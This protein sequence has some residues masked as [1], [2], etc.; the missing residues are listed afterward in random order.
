[1]SAPALEL[2][3][4]QVIVLEECLHR[5]NDRSM[6]TRVGGLAGT[7]KTSIAVR[8]PEWLG[9]PA[10]QVAFCA[11]TGRAANNL[12]R[13]LPEGVR[14]TTIDEL[15]FE[16]IPL[17]CGACPRL[18]WKP[19]HEGEEEPDCHERRKNRCKCGTWTKVLRS[20]LPGIEAIVV[21]ESSMVTEEYHNYLLRFRTP[22]FFFG[23]HGQLPPVGD[24]HSLMERP[25]ITLQQIHR[26]QDGSPIIDLALA[27]RETGRIPLGEIGR[28]VRK[29]RRD[30]SLSWGENAISLFDVTRDS[31]MV[32]CWRN[33]TRVEV[34]ALIREA[35]G[36]EG[37]PPVEGERLICLQNNREKRIANG[38]TGRLLEIE[39][40][41][42]VLYRI[43]VALDDEGRKY[44]G[45][46]LRE[47]FNEP[48]TLNSPSREV[49][50]WDFGYCKTVH[51]AQGSE[52]KWVVLLDEYPL[53][54]PDRRRWAYT[55]VTRA[56]SGLLVIGY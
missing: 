19:E 54:L 45:A 27:V 55:G 44:E 5:F 49:D 25:D 7:G 35:R 26:Q 53:V 38:M 31:V 47:Q 42:P 18:D 39:V 1:M 36:I 14:A 52:A 10:D 33:K 30:R 3:T 32:L 12:T 50:L 43:V 9:L 46:A 21:D 29:V 8:L 56:T 23:D 34:N 13:R 20:V 24:K 16:A 48:E 4:D 28:N 37:G 51:K 11:Y 6:E 15:V 41:T 40:I 2:S 22:V 17:H